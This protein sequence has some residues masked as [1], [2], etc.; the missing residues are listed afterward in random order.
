MADLDRPSSADE[1]YLARG[2]EVEPYRPILTGDVFEGI[3]VPGT[4]ADAG[5]AMV[6]AHPCSMRRGAHMR[7]YVQMAPVRDG[8]PIGLTAWGRGHYG[9]M[10]LPGLR[11]PD[12][13]RDRAVF[14]DACRVPT[15]WLH[16]ARRLACLSPQ[17]IL[18]L[19]QRL[20][21]NVTRHAVELET[22]KKAIDYVLE[23]AE[24]LEEWMRARL[25]LAGGEHLE[26]VAARIREQ[27]EAFD[28]VL[29]REVDGKTLRDLL[30][31]PESRATV[32]R[33]VRA[34]MTGGR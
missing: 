8:D 31:N 12:D 11:A 32:R 6:V 15:E 5:L 10:P 27:E 3:V 16:R 33:E 4:D 17:G 19:L 24:L 20:T 18:L 29:R 30:R 2:D 22:L 13:L 28:E 9:V 23:E 1:L 25:D 7:P 34:A 21:F 14:E 26:N